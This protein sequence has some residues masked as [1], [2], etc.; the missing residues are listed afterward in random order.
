MR[1]EPSPRPGAQTEARA[2]QYLVSQGWL[3]EASNLSVNGVQ[4]DLIARDPQGLRVIVEV[5][6]GASVHY[7]I[8]SQKQKK[9]LRVVQ[10]RLAH[11]EPTRLIA[12]IEEGRSRFREIPIED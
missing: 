5:K 11:D 4:I 1:R 9:R 10:L 3:I 8:L 7:G 2:A 6:S 12:L